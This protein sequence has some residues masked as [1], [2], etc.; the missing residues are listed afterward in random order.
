MLEMNK[1]KAGETVEHPEWCRLLEDDCWS[2]LADDIE[3][4]EEYCKKCDFHKDNNP[5]NVM[6]TADDNERGK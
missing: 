1:M 4:T 3:T 5:V 6:F 2:V